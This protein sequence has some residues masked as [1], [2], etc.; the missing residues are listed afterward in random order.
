MRIPRKIDDRLTDAIVNIQF[1]PGVPADAVVGYFH[2]LA[3][4]LYDVTSGNNTPVFPPFNA[5]GFLIEQQG[6][7]AIDSKSGI[8]VDVSAKQINFNITAG[9]R[10]WDLYSGLIGQTLEPLFAQKVIRKVN[11]LGLRYVSDFKQV[12]V[13]EQINATMQIQ[14]FNPE[15]A[16]T[17][18]RTEFQTDSGSYAIVSLS[19]A[20]PTFVEQTGQPDGGIS[21]R[22]DIDIIR[23]YDSQEAISF[24]QL[25][26]QVHQAHDEQKQLFFSLLKDEFV[27]TLNPQD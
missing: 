5:P 26:T 21:S 6:F 8:R 19:N 16:K 2:N 11:R 9:Y 12:R 10:G 20:Y 17:Q 3:G 14:A 18:F 13:F 15:L 27:Q 1:N 4:N 7:F 25:I 23:G 24:D 22:V